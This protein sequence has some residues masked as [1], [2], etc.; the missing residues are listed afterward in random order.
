MIQPFTGMFEKALEFALKQHKGQHRKSSNM[1]YY[2]HP[3]SVAEN[4][5]EVKQSKNLELLMTA[6]ILHDTVEDCPGVTI[7]KIANMFGYQVASLVDELTS[8]PKQVALLGKTEYLKQKMEKMTSY[9]LVIKLSDRLH[10]IKD[11]AS[12]SVAFR[13]SYT[14]ETLA[15]IDYLESWVRKLTETH[16]KLLKKIREW[17]TL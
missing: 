15:I 9:G 17:L 13:T 4:I 6:A 14:K 8:D 2:R 3:I 1:P 10:N 12:T 11:L 7:K 16:K 5:E